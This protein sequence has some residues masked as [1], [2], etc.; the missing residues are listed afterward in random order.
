MKLFVPILASAGVSAQGGVAPIMAPIELPSPIVQKCPMPKLPECRGKQPA[1]CYTDGILRD[2]SCA[3]E[4]PVNNPCEF[5]CAPR[6]QVWVFSNKVFNDFKVPEKPS[7]K[8]H[9]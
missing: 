7:L 1:K 4:D 5:Y 8:N 2:E 9:Q 3:Q 6:D